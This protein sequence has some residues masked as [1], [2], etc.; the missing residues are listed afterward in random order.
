MLRCDVAIVGAGP[1]GSTAARFLAAAGVDT[2]LLERDRLPRDKPC[3]GGLRP[4]VVRRIDHIKRLAGRFVEAISNEAVISTPGGP[5]VTH[6]VPEGAL[7]IMFQMRRSVFDQ[8]LVEDAV[9]QGARLEEGAR[10]TRA[11]GGER[12]WKLGLEDGRE[13]RAKAVIGAGG[14]NCPISKRMRVAGGAPRCFP[15]DRLAVCWT[16]EY[17]VGERFVEDAYGDSRCIHMT[18]RHADVTGYAWAFPKREHVNVGFGALIVDLRGEDGHKLAES[19]VG[20]LVKRGLLPQSP[21]GGRWQAAPI[22]MGGPAGPVVRPGAL[23]IG[24]AAGFVSPLAG[25]GIYYAIE[26]GRMAAEVMQ[27]ALG[28]GDM[29]PEFLHDY[30]RAWKRA[31]GGELETLWKVATKLSKDPRTVLERAESDPKMAPIVLKLFQGEGDV[32]RNAIALYGRNALAAL[33]FPRRDEER[34]DDEEPC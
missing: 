12:G 26:S 22:P 6:R 8:V 25:D 21:G 19:Y 32:S 17:E 3:G 15:R 4:G 23:A 24:D 34:T 2:L 16:R 28:K 18:L 33:R 10:V 30:H 27:R 7:P 14:A 9:A 31:W 1:A 5:F 20:Q 11:A 29:T 13:V